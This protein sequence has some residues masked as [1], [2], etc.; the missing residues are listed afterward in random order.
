MISPSINILILNWNGQTVLLDCVKSILKSD[1]EN[2]YITIID[3][4]STDSSLKSIIA[5]NS[6]IINFIKINQNVGYAKAYNY[7]FERIINNKHDFYFILNND[8]VILPDTL[9]KLILASNKYGDN[10]IYGPKILNFFDETIWYAGGK[11]S[12]FTFSANNIGINKSNS[13]TEYKTGK[14]DFVSGCSL[15]IKKDILNKIG[16]FNEIYKFYYEDVDLCLKA[17]SLNINSIFVNN[18]LVKHKI[19]HSMGGR[20]SIFKLYLKL[21]SKIKFII[22][23]NSF[24]KSILYLLINIFLLPFYLLYKMIIILFK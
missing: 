1:Y 23:N 8:T 2:Y 11:L 22:S 24:F 14:T 21:V 19:S 18:S 5:L 13:I 7:A 15:F 10:N 17:K 12:S 6:N 16:G 4:G 3:N 9:S 20:Y